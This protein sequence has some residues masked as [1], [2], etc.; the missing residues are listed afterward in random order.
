MIY[1]RIFLGHVCWVAT[2]KPK[3]QKSWFYLKIECHIPE[4]KKTDENSRPKGRPDEFLIPSWG[5]PADSQT[6]LLLLLQ[7]TRSIGI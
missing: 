3:I 5:S 6:L 1:A 2:F 7:N 4:E